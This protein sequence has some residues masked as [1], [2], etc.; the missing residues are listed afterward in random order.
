L[1]HIFLNIFIFISIVFILIILYST[2]TSISRKLLLFF[3]IVFIYF[4]PQTTNDLS[5][6]IIKELFNFSIHTKNNHAKY[7][8]KLTPIKSINNDLNI[9]LIMSESTRYKNLSLFGYEK[10]T[11]PN[12]IKYKNFLFYKTIY[13]GATNT[14][15]SIPL[16]LN[17]AIK[18]NQIDFSYNLFTLAK[19]NHFNSTFTSTQSNKS[20]QYIK[21]YLGEDIS[22]LSILGTKDDKDLY[23]SYIKDIS[24][25]GNHFCIYQMIAQHSP[26]NHYPSNFNIYKDNSIISK[27]NNSTIYT[28]YVLSLFLDHITKSDK[29]TILIFTSDH[30]ELIGE[31]NQYG[32]NRFHKDIYTVPLIVYTNNID[33]N[34]TY[35]KQIYTHHDLYIYLKYLLGYTNKPIYLNPPYIINGTM[36]TQEDGYIEVY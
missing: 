24:K 14:D 7:T 28:D 18:F 17:G 5:F 29:P 13:S 4:Q 23:N 26:Y 10:N 15:V 33:I 16:F 2:K 1:N 30:A 36:Q 32:H 20:L 31:N 27:Y 6:K 8:Q 9:I 22:N 35:L 11:T 21:P 25:K 34:T 19:N 12:L 3:G